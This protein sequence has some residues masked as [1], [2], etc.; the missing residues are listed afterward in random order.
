MI[1]SI[2]KPMVSSM[3]SGITGADGG[4][5]NS[6]GTIKCGVVISCGLVWRC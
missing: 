1:R 6:N 3:V 4:I 2:I 5:W